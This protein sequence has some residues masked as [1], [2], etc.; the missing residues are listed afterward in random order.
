M[1]PKLRRIRAAST[2]STMLK[3]WLEINTAAIRWGQLDCNRFSGNTILEPKRSDEQLID[4]KTLDGLF[5]VNQAL[6]LNNFGSIII[7]IFSLLFLFFFRRPNILAGF[8]SSAFMPA[9]RLFSF[10]EFF[11]HATVTLQTQKHRRA[12]QNLLFSSSFSFGN[13]RQFINLFGIANE[14]MPKRRICVNSVESLKSPMNNNKT[15]L[16]T[17]KNNSR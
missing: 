3:L 5:N 6:S 13:I 15:E 17:K 2:D 1:T 4:R 11:V 16:E 7:M 8:L 10:L 9:Y 14:R 12:K